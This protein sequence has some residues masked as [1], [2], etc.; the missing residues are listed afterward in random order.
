MLN[1]WR[2]NVA[3]LLTL[4]MGAVLVNLTQNRTLGEAFP[5]I[6]AFFGS[7]GLAQYALLFRGHNIRNHPALRAAQQDFM[8]GDFESVIERL[9]EATSGEIADGTRVQMLTLQ[10]NAYR[11]LGQL[12]ES[13]DVLQTA[14]QLDAINPFPLYGLGRTLLVMGNYAEAENYL[15]QALTNGAKKSI[16]ADWLLAQYY[17]ELDADELLKSALQA[18]KNLRMEA[19]RTLMVNYVLYQLYSA[20]NPPNQGQ[21]ELAQNIMNNTQTGLAFWTAE[22]ERFSATDYGQ[23]LGVDVQQMKDLVEH[24]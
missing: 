20:Q 9:N 12:A 17:A 3:L 18:S 10:G 1:H 6:I 16:R 5:L 11:Q 13:L 8:Q 23:R 4:G 2:L 21:R 15:G 7:L 14:V 24:S 22:A 19:H